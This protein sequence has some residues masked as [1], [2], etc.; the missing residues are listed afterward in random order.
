MKQNPFK[1]KM[2]SWKVDTKGMTQESLLG[3]SPAFFLNSRPSE[4]IHSLCVI[5]NIQLDGLQI[6]FI[7]IKG[8]GSYSAVLRTL[9]WVWFSEIK[10]IGAMGTMCGARDET[11]V[12]HMQGKTLP[13][14]LEAPAPENTFL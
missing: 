7:K 12:G 3:N 11:R 5:P 14:V 10:P 4:K 2:L 6:Q 13:T 8:T 9:S 1:V